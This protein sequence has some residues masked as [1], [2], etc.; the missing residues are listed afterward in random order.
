V[1]A[2]RGISLRGSWKPEELEELDDVLAPLPSAWVEENP[3]F[4]I[5]AREPVLRN[6]PPEAPGHSK[7][8]PQLGA[9]VVY[10]KGVYHGG[11]L[12]PEQFRRSIYHELAHSIIRSNPQL[13][14]QWGAETDGDGFVDDYA[15]TSPEEDFADTLSE[16][17]IHN[18]ETV[19][20]VPRKAA[21][22]ERLL[23]ETQEKVAMHFMNAFADE[24]VK[25]A[26]VKSLLARAARSNLGKLSIG[27][28]IGGM[29]GL[30]AGEQAGEEKGY[31][32]G[33]K[34]MTTVARYAH[35]RGMQ[36]GARAVI[37]HL[38]MQQQQMQSQKK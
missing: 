16:F 14:K 17:F 31:Q 6:A 22:L 38:R 10:D 23:N 33:T 9:I 7:Y 18:R 36:D 4:R 30:Y 13:L 28:G 27:G 12:D 19:K 32:S 20:L 3:S 35:Q 15:K 25:T 2:V 29:A 37:Q 11:K 21:F 5:L 8:E 1:T 24:L 26:N 34:D